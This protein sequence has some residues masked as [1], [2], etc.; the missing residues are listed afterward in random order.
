MKNRLLYILLAAA[1]LLLFI[2]PPHLH[3]SNYPA[4]DSYFYLQVASNIT[5]G[6][7]STFN[8]ITTTNGYH[9]L[10]MIVC[11][12]AVRAVG[13]NRIAALHITIATQQILA[14]FIM[15]FF[16]RLAKIIKLRYWFFAIPFLFL[17]FSTRLYC[18]EAY[19]NGYFVMMTMVAAAAALFEDKNLRLSL[20]AIVGVLGGLAVLSRLD[21]IFLIGVL[22]SVTLVLALRRESRRPPTFKKFVTYAITIGFPCLAVIIPYIVLNYVTTGHPAPV[23]GAIKSTLPHLSFN[24]NGLST[25]G[26]ACLF[27]AIASPVICLFANCD[28]RRRF[29]V[30]VFSAGFILHM[31]QIILTTNHH[32]GWPWYYV[33]GMINTAVILC[34]IAESLAERISSAM[35][36]LRRAVAPNG[37]LVSIALLFS[38]LINGYALARY[39]NPAPTIEI[40]S[41][42]SRLKDPPQERW[43]EAL[44]Y[45]LK[46]NM[47]NDSRIMIY[48]WP[49]IIAYFSEVKI[50]APD[51]L[52]N[53]YQYNDDLREL[54]IKKYLKE[55]K[56][57]YWLGPTTPTAEN[58]QAW[59]TLTVMPN[60]QKIEIFA[61]LYKESVGSFTIS[62]TNRV[63]R[64]QD[65]VKHRDMPD[66]SLWKI[67]L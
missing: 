5:A 10:W 14:L 65:V 24:F 29:V 49:G 42:I 12:S 33:S 50:L 34:I 40:S 6:H 61:P 67:T 41:M 13:G 23:S 27:F 58:N 21:N 52:I 16:Y 1:A 3:P 57:G 19:L 20:L 31:L 35:P 43:Q 32:T 55:K 39:R 46:N 44:G 37:P 15:I 7:G 22:F 51:G 53:D 2:V 8:Q 66:L 4:D 11:R 47:P 18:S 54:G 63:A 36:A 62:N 59:Y 28:K 56:I 64:L 45:W 26:K 25:L 30:F 9:P 17:Y 48:D 38:I 60:S